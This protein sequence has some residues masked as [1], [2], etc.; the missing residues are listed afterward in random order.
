MN[1][2]P[3]TIQQLLMRIRE[4]LRC[5]QCRKHM[6]VNLEALKVLGENFAVMQMQCTACDA[7]IMLHATI[8]YGKKEEQAVGKNA[9]TQ[10]MVDIDDIKALET[11][12][13]KSNGSFM[14]LFDTP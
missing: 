14:K 4:Q 13:Q 1:I 8:A 11:S 3:H 10:L 5:P 6:D 9:S 7:H 12:L 2:D